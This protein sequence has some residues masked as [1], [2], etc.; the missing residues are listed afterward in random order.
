MASERLR[1]YGI[2][3]PKANTK[4]QC[5]SKPSHCFIR[6]N[7]PGILLEVRGSICGDIAK[8]SVVPSQIILSGYAG[9]GMFC[10]GLAG[11]VFIDARHSA[12]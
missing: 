3:L 4:F 11:L 9:I 10:T 6:F 8:A 2:Y 1:S 7:P 12:D 5:Y